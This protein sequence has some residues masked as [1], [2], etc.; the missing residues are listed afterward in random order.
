MAVLGGLLSKKDKSKPKH[1]SSVASC[2]VANIDIDSFNDESEY[3]HSRLHPN[4]VYQ[5]AAASSSK[6]KVNLAP[7]TRPPPQT[8]AAFGGYGDSGNAL[9][10]KSL[11]NVSHHA[12]TNSFRNRGSVV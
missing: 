5:N 2:A 9:S 10:A 1:P 11:S 3:D 12:Q 8:C 7:S 4:T 6:S